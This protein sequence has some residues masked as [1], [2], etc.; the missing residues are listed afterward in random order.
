MTEFER[1]Q[2]DRRN[3]IKKKREAI[4]QENQ[5]WMPG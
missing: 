5:R 1:L 4:G 2:T 3:F